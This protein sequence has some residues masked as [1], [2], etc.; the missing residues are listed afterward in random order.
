VNARGRAFTLIELLVVIVIL[1]VAS[2][3]TIPLFLSNTGHARLKDST[4]RLSDMVRFCQSMAVFQAAPFRL[5]L[6][7][8]KGRCW[9]SFERDPGRQPG[10]F[11]PYLQSEYGGYTLQ[12]G[13]RFG[14]LA[15]GD[16]NTETA[17]SASEEE[18]IEFR[19]D[20]TADQTAIV[21][22][23]QDG[24]AYSLIVSGLTGQVF[25]VEGAFKPEDK[26]E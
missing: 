26:E 15:L 13:V 7:R 12:E 10:V 24:E 3:V 22:E 9:V 11:S 6:D 16:E 19:K 20:G 2:A 4:T 17:N 5:N 18:F 23:G 14:D 21:L 8:Q 25:I 1:S